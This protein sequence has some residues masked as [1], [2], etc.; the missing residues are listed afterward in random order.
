MERIMKEI[1]FM[2]AKNEVIQKFVNSGVNFNMAT[3][4]NKWIAKDVKLDTVKF[5]LMALCGE[6]K[7]EE[8]YNEAYTLYHETELI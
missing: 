6:E 7:A 3:L 2:N 8:L 5:D 1:E 4:M